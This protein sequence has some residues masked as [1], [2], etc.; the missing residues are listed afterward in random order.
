MTTAAA[1]AALGEV[2]AWRVLPA[3]ALSP[4]PHPA[5]AA[6]TTA[7]SGTVTA[8][9]GPP[10]R[11]CA[12]LVQYP[13]AA[14][15]LPRP[16]APASSTPVI[17]ALAPGWFN[18]RRRIGV[19]RGPRRSRPPGTA[20]PVAGGGGLLLGLCEIAPGARSE[21]MTPPHVPAIGGG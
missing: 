21:P 20:R 10:S 6:V 11:L 18:R 5:A 1:E 4:P 12:V 3:V 7:A 17:T 2:P 9:P 13:S 16:Q 8:H 14:S 19:A 15:F